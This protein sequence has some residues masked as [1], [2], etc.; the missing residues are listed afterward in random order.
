MV[1]IHCLKIKRT[2]LERLVLPPFHR[3]PLDQQV[4]FHP[5]LNKYIIYRIL[6]IFNNI[7]SFFLTN[8]LIIKTIKEYST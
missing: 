5:K 3:F 1:I 4:Q 6:Y 7:N 8:I 2:N